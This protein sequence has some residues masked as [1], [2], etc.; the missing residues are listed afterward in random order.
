MEDLERELKKALSYID[1]NWQI[2]NN[3]NDYKSNFVYKVETVDEI[4][5]L[6][7]QNG[8]DYKYALHRWYNFKTSIYCENVF[9]KNGAVKERDFRNKEIDI[10]INDVPFDVKL[11]VYPKA[12]SH[13]P[14]D[15][16]T[17][18]GKDKMIE[19]MYKNQS[20][21]QR[22]HLANRLFIVC[23]GENQYQ[24]LCLK[25]DFEQLKTKIK[26]YIYEVN[27]SGFNQLTIED[28]GNEYT[29]LSDIIYVK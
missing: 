26:E 1:E 29:V 15:L 16:T 17:R 25:S 21:Q 20:Q 11:T 12:L 4:I 8:I 28:N 2:Q 7:K 19:W 5:N 27:S 23:D 14:Y 13:H 22:K 10:Y 24:S 6:S 9:V 18:E 3:F